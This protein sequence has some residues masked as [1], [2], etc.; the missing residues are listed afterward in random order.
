MRS[1]TSGR[2]LRRRRS[3]VLA[4]TVTWLLGISLTRPSFQAHVWPGAWNAPSPCR[5]GSAEGRPMGGT[6][7]T[8]A[9]RR[10]AGDNPETAEAAVGVGWGRGGGT[11]GAAA[12]LLSPPGLGKSGFPCALDP[13]EQFCDLI[14]AL[15]PSLFE[16]PRVVSLS[17]LDRIAH[18]VNYPCDSQFRDV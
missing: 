13:V 14:P 1:M 8:Q 2:T 16:T 5:Q 12:T 11:S 6:R 3:S 4:Q 15:N 10:E 9:G 18:R 17:R 7:E